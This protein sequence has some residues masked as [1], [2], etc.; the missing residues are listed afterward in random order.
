MHGVHGEYRVY[1]VR[2][3]SYILYLEWCPVVA[4]A[5]MATHCGIGFDKRTKVDSVTW[6]VHVLF[7][8]DTTV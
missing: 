1:D 8:P 6:Q 7:A 2:I 5:G 3:Y 4:I